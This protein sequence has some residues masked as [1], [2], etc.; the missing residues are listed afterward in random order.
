MRAALLI[1]GGAGG[2]RF[3]GKVGQW[4]APVNLGGGSGGADTPRAPVGGPQP[5]PTVR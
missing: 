5:H 3:G 2:G 4:T 1:Y